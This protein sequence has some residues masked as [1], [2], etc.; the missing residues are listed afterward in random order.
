MPF[1]ATQLDLEIVTL[2]EI[3]QTEK[4]K[5]SYDSPYMWILKRNDTN[6]LTYKTEGGSETQ[7]VNLWLRVGEGGGKDRGK[8]QFGSLGW[9]HTHC[10]TSN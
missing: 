7:R 5:Y 9:T 2:S 1:A 6:R 10:Y 4:E 3:C 8:G